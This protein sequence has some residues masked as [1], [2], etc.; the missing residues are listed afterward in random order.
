MASATCDPPKHRRIRNWVGS[1]CGVTKQDERRKQPVYMNSARTYSVQTVQNPPSAPSRPY[2]HHHVAAASMVQLPSRPAPAPAYV[3]YPG[4]IQ[5]SPLPSSQPPKP[6]TTTSS[7]LLKLK[8][9]THLSQSVSN[10][11]S[12]TTGKANATILELEDLVLQSL[13]GGKNVRGA[14]S[15]LLDRVIT[16][17]DIG[18]FCGREN[19]LGE[20]LSTAATFVSNLL[21]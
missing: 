19:E 8:S 4:P 13:G 3:Q 11:V 10:L 21:R 17:I 15:Q 2:P 20:L 9:C 5:G 1:T 16:V 6:K 18:S 14:T 12:H 7:D